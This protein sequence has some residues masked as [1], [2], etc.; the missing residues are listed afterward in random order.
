MPREILS[1]SPELRDH[2]TTF[3][4]MPRGPAVTKVQAINVNYLTWMLT[5]HQNTI[6]LPPAVFSVV[7]IP[8]AI[9]WPGLNLP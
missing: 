3:N 6:D 8:M 1:P 5:L 7:R 4:W 9:A 2:I